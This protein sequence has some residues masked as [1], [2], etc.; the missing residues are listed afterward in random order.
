MSC[1]PEDLLPKNFLIFNKIL[2]LILKTLQC[3]EMYNVLCVSGGGMKGVCELGAAHYLY[4]DT[5]LLTSIDTYVGTSI[6][7]VISLLLCIGYTP[8]QIFSRVSKIES[9]LDFEF[10][11][12][13]F[14]NFKK[15]YGLLDINQ[16]IS[17]IENV[18]LEKLGVI[19]TL[20]ELY[21][22][23]NKRIVIVVT[24][25]TKGIV[26]Y[27]DYETKPNIK[28]TEAIKMSCSLPVVFDRVLY[29]GDIYIDGGIG[30]NFPIEYAS[31]FGNVIGIRVT[32]NNTDDDFFSYMHRIFNVA[33]HKIETM[34][35]DHLQ[36]I[37][38]KNLIVNITT[39]AKPLD[40]SDKNKKMKMFCQGYE[41]TK[42]VCFEND[43]SFEW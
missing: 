10:D 13:N 41:A 39:D 27:I 4:F 30:D 2:N 23:F 29:E 11:I 36:V 16:F 24:N 12:F 42:I 5:D 15:G 33:V 35:L 21:K 20:L 18:V 37:K 32:G 7:A 14:L 31:K 26:E 19:P 1:N 22:I 25:Y 3:K 40:N 38:S 34:Q 43:L 8:M 28:C 17:K 6:G 9:F